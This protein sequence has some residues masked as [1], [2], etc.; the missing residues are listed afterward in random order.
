MSGVAHSTPRAAVEGVEPPGDAKTG[1]IAG[2]LGEALTYSKIGRSLVKVSCV[3]SPGSFT[4]GGM[5]KTLTL[6]I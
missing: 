2:P 4:P 6:N 1:W 3:S 5:Y